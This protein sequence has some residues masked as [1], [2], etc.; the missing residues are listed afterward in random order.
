MD[1]LETKAL[2]NMFASIY[3]A[4]ML[5]WLVYCGVKMS[6]APDFSGT[7]KYYG[8]F[9]IGMMWFLGV[10]GVAVLIFETIRH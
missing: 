9:L 4:C 10:L 8:V 6:T 7:S 5:A 2:M 3:F 1:Y